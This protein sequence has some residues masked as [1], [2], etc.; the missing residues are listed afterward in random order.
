MFAMFKVRIL[1][2]LSENV[3][4]DVKRH[5]LSQ[6]LYEYI[7][8]RIANDD[9]EFDHLERESGDVKSLFWDVPALSFTLYAKP[10]DTR[11]RIELNSSKQKSHS[12]MYFWHGT[13]II[14]ITDCYIQSADDAITNCLRMFPVKKSTI[15]HELSH[16]LDDLLLV[17]NFRDPKMYGVNRDNQTGK[18]Q[19][20]RK[21]FNMGLELNARWSQVIED[22]TINE[23]LYMEK[24]DYA[25]EERWLPISKLVFRYSELTP[26]KKRNF[27]S[28]L[29]EL[30]DNSPYPLP[31]DKSLEYAK[32][33]AKNY[34][35]FIN[36]LT[37]NRM[38]PRDEFNKSQ[39]LSYLDFDYYIDEIGQPFG[40][41]ISSDLSKANKDKIV[42]LAKSW[43]SHDEQQVRAALEKEFANAA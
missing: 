38:Y 1:S 27:I 7:M 13:P 40:N 32:T 22:L 6:E 34:R 2:K 10:I 35:D 9:V 18:I 31:S 28:K 4:R 25:F 5:Q 41:A 21:Y 36:D 43:I 12:G 30:Y 17:K 42:S 29:Y 3:Q 16:M 15:I 11:I 20:D 14:E 24:T 39:L 26:Q 8:S 37:S 19:Y 23:F 33:I